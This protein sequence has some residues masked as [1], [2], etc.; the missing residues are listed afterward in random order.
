MTSLSHRIPFLS[1]LAGVCIAASTLA[2][3]PAQPRHAASSEEN[4]HMRS[5]LYI[6]DLR[7]N[8]THLVFTADTVWEAP[9]WSPD[10]SYLIANSHGAISKFVLKA[11]G[12]AEPQKLSIPAGYA[13]N[14]DKAIS[15]DGK[16]LAF[17]ATLAPSKGSQ[18]FLANA[19]GTGIQLMAAQ[20]PS[21][22]HGWSPDSKALAFV[23]IRNGEHQFDI[24]RVPASGGVEQRLTMNPHHD[25]G[26]D[27]SPDGKW[28]YINS[29]RSGKEAAWRFPADG[30]GPNDAKAEMVVSDNDEDWFP[31]ISPDGKKLVYLT[32]P[33]GT[34]THDP[35]DVHIEFK[36]VDI[37]D[38][39]VAKTQKTL[40][41]AMGGQ[42]SMNVNSWAPDSMRFAYITYEALP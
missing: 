25:D 15:P 30:A 6:Y 28:I 16:K 7:D 36:L 4:Q 8:S 12:T 11:D 22:F 26:P 29:D 14:N 21:Y 35:R 39:Q 5:R 1:L 40:T 3:Q 18:V 13:C 38:G 2:A 32:Y 42:G 10:G 41:K 19:D 17:S 9:N 20:P 23:A 33:A 27:Y 24:Y 31:H 37:V 34:P